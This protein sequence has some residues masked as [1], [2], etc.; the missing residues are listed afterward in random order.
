MSNKQEDNEIDRFF[1]DSIDNIETE[2]SDRFWNKAYE[3]ILKNENKGYEQRLMLWRGISVVLALSVS[4]LI[5]YNIYTNHKVTTIEKQ[6]ATIEHKEVQIPAQKVQPVNNPST[7]LAKNAAQQEKNQSSQN[8]TMA[9]ETMPA[10]NASIMLGYKV[11]RNGPWQTT[12]RHHQHSSQDIAYSDAKHGSNSEMYDRSA[13]KNIIYLDERT[14]SEITMHT[15][16]K[17]DSALS[18]LD[19]SDSLYMV[20]IGPPVAGVS[21]RKILSKLSVNAFGAPSIVRQTMKD[22]NPNDNISIGDIQSKE[23]QQSGYSAGINLGFDLSPRFT[24]EAGLCYRVYKYTISPTTVDVNTD[25]LGDGYSFATSSGTIYMPY[26]PAYTSTGYD[27]TATANGHIIR[28]YVSIP[29]RLKYNFLSSPRFG[30]YISAGG[31]ANVLVYN[32]A[33]VHCQNTWGQEDVYVYDMEGATPV[34]FSYLLGLGAEL[35]LGR[36]FAIYAEP[37][38]MGA[39]TPNIKSKAMTIYS[40]YFDFAGG[41]SY[42]F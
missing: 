2:P 27:T 4:A 3:G 14:P 32:Y 19:A 6:I 29:L 40:S 35:K 41:L 15:L 12:A 42:H 18:A 11:N 9:H 5:A 23:H 24:L 8:G 7:L 31:A 22:N 38:Y 17:T 16:A 20:P 21:H 34:N 13:I 1:R 25:E 30:V 37:T 10:R 36:G 39:I 33:N 26:I 28:S